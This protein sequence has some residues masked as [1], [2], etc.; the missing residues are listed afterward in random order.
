MGSSKNGQRRGEGETD[1]WEATQLRLGSDGRWWAG[2]GGKQETTSGY[3]DRLLKGL[4][5]LVVGVLGTRFELSH[6]ACC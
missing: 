3:V 1:S 6:E 4:S 2:I 5:P